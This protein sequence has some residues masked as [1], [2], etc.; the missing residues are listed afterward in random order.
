MNTEHLKYFLEIARCQSISQAAEQLHLQRSYLS[1]IVHNFERELGITIFKRSPKGIITTEKGQY[2]LNRAA[3]ILAIIDDIYAL[4]PPKTVFPQYH[5]KITL[6][7]P[8][9]FRP[10]K[11]S[12]QYLP[13]FQQRFPNVVISMIEYNFKEVFQKILETPLSLAT[14]GRLDVTSKFNPPIPDDL[15]FYSL[16]TSSLVA[17][18]APNNQLAKNY[19]TMTLAALAK[20][21]LVL[22]DFAA[23][24]DSLIY[25]LLSQNGA[26][27]VKC[28]VSPTFLFYQLLNNNPYFSVGVYGTDF[29]DDLLQIPLRDNIKVELGLLFHKDTL[30]NIVGRSYIDILLEH[31]QK[32]P[33]PIEP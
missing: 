27:N 25:Q 12:M 21:E 5:D 1:K 10:H 33:L 17:L 6:F 14:Y 8:L 7:L 11:A 30:N 26:P 24:E 9:R 3:E 20:Q 2:I 28:S 31:Y 18:A 22:F 19:Q 4:G 13:K 23:K 32:P 29:N 16:N 15:I